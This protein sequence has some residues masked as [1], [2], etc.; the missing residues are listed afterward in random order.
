[1]SDQPIQVPTHNQLFCTNCGKPVSEHAVACMACGATPVGHRKF[2]RYCGVALNPEQVVC[3]KCGAALAATPMH[4][5]GGNT[6]VSATTPQAK[7]LNTYF[8]IMWICFAAAIPT[9]GL[10]VLPGVVFMY[11]LLYQL[12]KLVPADI[13]Q[14]SP[15][16]AVGFCFIPFFNFYWVPFVALKGLGEDMNRTL[17]RYGIQYQ[18]N[19]N[20]GLT[21]VILYYCTIL[22]CLITLGLVSIAYCVIMILYIKSVKD[23]AVALLEQGG[24]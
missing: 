17:Q 20:L 16:K 1:M 19:M 18:V 14:T 24:E 6:V 10:G 9:C 23:G 2:C 21:V 5:S 3:T 12:W 7:S 8:M 22:D 4:P 11:I 15:G 13:A